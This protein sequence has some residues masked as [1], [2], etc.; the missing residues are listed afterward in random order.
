MVQGPEV[1]RRVVVRAVLV[2]TRGRARVGWVAAAGH[3]LLPVVPGAPRGLELGEQVGN[4]L[5]AARGEGVVGLAARELARDHRDV[6]PEAARARE[7]A[8]VRQPRAARAQ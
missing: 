6:L 1:Q 4:A 8:V 2:V 5:V 7:G 3:R